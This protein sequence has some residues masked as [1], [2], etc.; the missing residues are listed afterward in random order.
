MTHV[1][2]SS[3]GGYDEFQEVMPRHWD[4]SAKE[5]SLLAPQ[6]RRRVLEAVERLPPA[7]RTL[8]EEFKKRGIDKPIIERIIGVLEKRCGLTRDRFA[9]IKASP[10]WSFR[11]GFDRGRLCVSSKNQRRVFL[12]VVPV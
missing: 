5:A 12:P 2:A 9:D 10:S 8:Q 6:V 7:A 3:R 1:S 4:R 11:I